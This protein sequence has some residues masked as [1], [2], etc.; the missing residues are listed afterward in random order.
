[1]C[2]CKLLSHASSSFYRSFSFVVL[3]N[4]SIRSVTCCVYMVTSNAKEMHAETAEKTFCF[5]DPG[6]LL[7]RAPNEEKYDSAGDPPKGCILCLAIAAQY[8]IKPVNYPF[9]EVK[10]LQRPAKK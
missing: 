8:F 10:A 7:S 4:S 5:A 3:G 1:M 2:V 6:S 9:N